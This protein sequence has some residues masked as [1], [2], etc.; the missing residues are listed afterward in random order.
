MTS[1]L[2]D[3]LITISSA[4]GRHV[5]RPFSFIFTKYFLSILV[6]GQILSLMIVSTNTFS[7]LLANRA[8]DIPTFQSLFNYVVLALI[9][10]TT[11][12]YKMGLGKWSGMIRDRGWKYFALAFVDV[13]ANYFVVKSY[14]YTTLLSCQLLDALAIVTVVVLSFLFF[15]VRYHWT[16]I[17]GI[18]VC[19][20]GLGMLVL[21]DFLTGKDSPGL[22]KVKGDLFMILGASLYGITNV[23]EE[24]FVS[25]APIYEVLGQLG[26]YGAIVNGIQVAILERDQLNNVRWDGKMGGYLVGFN[27]SMGILYSGTPIL[28]RMSSAVFYN[29]SLLSSDFWGLV[30]GTQLFGYNLYWLYVISFILVIGGIVLY[31]AVERN[32]KGEAEKPWLGRKEGVVGVG[33]YRQCLLVRDPEIEV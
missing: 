32:I 30:V 19:L 26:L 11:S 20:G 25:K 2:V 13:E 18:V 21:S 27:I 24:F 1:K 31:Y 12:I 10:T 17:L 29:L 6:L 4:E 22:D 9:Y 28:L 23:F 3:G 16:K 15:K 14:K 33:T 5:K 8:D 7:Q